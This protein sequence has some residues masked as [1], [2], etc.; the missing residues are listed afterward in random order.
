VKPQIHT[1]GDFGMTAASLLVAGIEAITQSR[2][3]CRLGLSGGSTPRAILVR[4]RALLPPSAYGRL[5]V[6]WVDERHLPVEHDAD[7]S[8]YGHHAD[9]NFRLAYEC[10]L[11][12]LPR[13]PSVVLPMSTGLTLEAD[14]ARYTRGF[15]DGFD[16]GLDV[17]LLGC[18]S[19]GHVASLFPGAETLDAK[20]P[21]LAITDSPKLPPERL[22]VTLPVIN[23]AAVVVLAAAGTSK[24]GV[25]ARAL[26]GDT[27][28]PLARVKA[29]AAYHWVLDNAAAAQLREG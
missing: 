24:A 28:L 4:L 25:L 10:W 1:G 18:G 19:D 14:L 5:A 23:R 8:W 3:R 13:P 12:R 29:T 27:A 16:S 20:E 6:T 2:G 15:A 22:T 11:A 26:A 17:V 21:V 9:S 7:P